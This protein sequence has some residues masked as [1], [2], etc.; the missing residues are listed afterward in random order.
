[1]LKIKLL[2][3]LVTESVQRG[4]NYQT[5]AELDSAD[6]SDITMIFDTVISELRDHQE[7]FMRLSVD[8][9]GNAFYI[10]LVQI[11]DDTVPLRLYVGT[12][13]GITLVYK[14]RFIDINDTTRCLC[15]YHATKE[16]HKTF[17]R[18]NANFIS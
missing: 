18:Y 4:V 15:V 5:I 1:M 7:D 13:N 16:M 9:R 10:T 17:D 2:S 3:D 14:N 11:N 6:A 8:H 12:T